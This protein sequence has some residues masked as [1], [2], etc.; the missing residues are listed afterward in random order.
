MTLFRFATCDRRMALGFLARFYPFAEVKD[1]GV[2]ADVLDLVEKDIIR[3]PDPS[4][5]NG[6]I[7]MSK[8]TPKDKKAAV[9]KKLQKMHDLLTA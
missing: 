8:K 9:V 5:H 7:T 3:I 6:V 4:F 1:E 2:T